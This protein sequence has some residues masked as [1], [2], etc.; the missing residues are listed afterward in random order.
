[1]RQKLF[2]KKQ[3]NSEVATAA[4]PLI[5]IDFLQ[6]EHTIVAALDNPNA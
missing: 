5:G 4:T 3:M 1:M 2:V 6:N